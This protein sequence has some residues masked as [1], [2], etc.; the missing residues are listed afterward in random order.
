MRF[1]A[2]QASYSVI[3]IYV[4]SFVCVIGG[5]KHNLKGQGEACYHLSKGC[6][7]IS[8]GRLLDMFWPNLPLFSYCFFF[9]LI[10]TSSKWPVK[11]PMN[12]IINVLARCLNVSSANVVSSMCFFFFCCCCLD[13][14]LVSSAFAMQEKSKMIKSTSLFKSHSLQRVFFIIPS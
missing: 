10:R 12:S 6:I 9:F 1:Q 11:L 5:C 4:F 14:T 8:K 7:Q 13:N 3:G 2:S